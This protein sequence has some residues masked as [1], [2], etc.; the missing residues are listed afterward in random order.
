[1]DRCNRLSRRLNAICEFLDTFTN[2]APLRIADAPR[3]RKPVRYV[4]RSPSEL[5][6]P[7][8]SIHAWLFME[9]MTSMILR[10]RSREML[11]CRARSAG[12]APWRNS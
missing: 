11:N 1:V 4:Y 7:W 6:A 5:S 3:R 2:G 8:A 9:G 10:I 12:R